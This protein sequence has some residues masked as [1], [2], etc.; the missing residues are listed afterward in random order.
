[1]VEDGLAMKPLVTCNQ[2]SD[3][4]LAPDL[5]SVRVER[6]WV[7]TGP[8]RT[9]LAGF[10][11][12]RQDPSLLRLDLAFDVERERTF[13]AALLENNVEELF[14]S[15]TK[16]VSPHQENFVD[17]RGGNRPLG[18]AELVEPGPGGFVF[19]KFRHASW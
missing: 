13:V 6:H 19:G 10:A 12:D 8:G 16:L 7:G 3:C 15:T 5:G 18:V 11:E 14:Q 9:N 17:E 4:A 1:M 2:V